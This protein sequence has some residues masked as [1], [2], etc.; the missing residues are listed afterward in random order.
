MNKVFLNKLFD[1][2]LSEKSVKITKEYRKDLEKF[3]GDKLGKFYITSIDWEGKI[4]LQS[5]NNMIFE[6]SDPEEC[7]DIKS[8]LK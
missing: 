4:T 8:I 7:F 3:V 1:I 6:N 5:E 2:M